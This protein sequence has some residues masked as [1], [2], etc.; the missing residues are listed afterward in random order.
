MR[1]LL[2]LVVILAGSLAAL[3]GPPRSWVVTNSGASGID[4]VATNEGVGLG[5]I[6]GIRVRVSSV[7]GTITG[8]TLCAYYLAQD[9]GSGAWSRNKGLDFTIPSV[10]RVDGGGVSSV[11]LPDLAVAGAFGRAV[12][13]ACGVTGVA[14]DGGTNSYS[15]TTEAYG[16]GLP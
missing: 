8:G 10:T 7:T 14:T 6:Q 13:V 2:F 15:V 12:W 1:R 4:P 11:T 5:Q 16:P 3:A 9:G